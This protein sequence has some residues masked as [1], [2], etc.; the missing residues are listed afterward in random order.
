MRQVPY[1]GP[2]NIRSHRNKFSRSGDLAPGFCTPLICISNY[3]VLLWQY[4]MD[5]RRQVCLVWFGMITNTTILV[6]PVR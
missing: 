1:L 6:H 4:L 3:L 2:T 5:H